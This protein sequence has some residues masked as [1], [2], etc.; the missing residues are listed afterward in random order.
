[1]ET[2]SMHTFHIQRLLLK[3][4]DIILIV[5]KE[6]ASAFFKPHQGFF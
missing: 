6:Q 4:T 2:M 5:N 3:G 1:M